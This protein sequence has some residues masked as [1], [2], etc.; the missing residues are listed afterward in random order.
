MIIQNG[1][2][3]IMECLEAANRNGVPVGKVTGLLT[4]FVPNRP[5]DNRRLPVRFEKNA[6]DATLATHK[7]RGDRPVRL[8]HEHRTLIGG[9]PLADI[10]V[11]N[12]GLL[13]TG[14]I[15]LETQLGQET[16]SLAKQ[17]VLSDFSIGYN[18]T[19]EHIEEGDLIADSIDLF[20]AS[21]VEEPANQ[22][23]K[24]SSLESLTTRELEKILLSTG[25][26]SRSMAIE[27][28][29]KIIAVGHIPT[30]EENLEEFAASLKEENRLAAAKQEAYELLILEM[31]DLRKSL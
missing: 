1:S 25:C 2:G 31:E 7:A 9:F 4:T 30:D 15:N 24:I 23:A 11:T 26:V 3:R 6:F 17:G 22:G 13:A 18:V 27:T 5:F 20:E 19:S 8:N 21:I 10:K 16:F 29:A 28:A 12:E 14:E